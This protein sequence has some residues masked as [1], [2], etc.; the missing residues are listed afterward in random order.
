[1]P[2]YDLRCSC[3]LEFE[4]NQPMNQTGSVQCPRCGKKTARRIISREVIVI[5]RYP[6]GHIRRTRGRD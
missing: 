6:D 4:Q 3:G 2:T 5:N 1:M